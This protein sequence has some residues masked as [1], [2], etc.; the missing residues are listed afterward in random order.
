MPD[1][2][3]GLAR[4]LAHGA[5]SLTHPVLRHALRAYF[6]PLGIEAAWLEAEVLSALES[7][8]GGW[9]LREARWRA[10]S[11]DRAHPAAGDFGYLLDRPDLFDVAVGAQGELAVKVRPEMAED[12]AA[13]AY[14]AGSENGWKAIR[15]SVSAAQAAESFLYA[16]AG[17]ILASDPSGELFAAGRDEEFCAAVEKRIAGLLAMPTP[18]FPR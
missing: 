14:L 1:P 10:G 9:W 12:P 6:L 16:A 15:H 18:A 3:P 13:A 7:G 5:T 8:S 2:L 17:S 11:F 4:W